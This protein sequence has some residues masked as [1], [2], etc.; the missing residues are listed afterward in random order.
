MD[1]EPPH[2][3]NEEA[4]KISIE[5]A[6]LLNAKILP[7]VEVMRKVVVDGSNTAGFQRTALIAYDGFINSSK[8]IIKIPTIFFM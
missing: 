5:I 3:I 4:V 1:S 8:G 6:K 2:L 7:E